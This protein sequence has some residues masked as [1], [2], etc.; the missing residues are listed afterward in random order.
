MMNGDKWDVTLWYI[1]IDPENH[2]FSLETNHPTPSHGRVVIL[3]YWRMCIYIYTH[4]QD[5][6]I[7][8]EPVHQLHGDHPIFAHRFEFR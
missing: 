4:M 5:L 3:I 7:H 2:Q 1:N 6:D 8:L